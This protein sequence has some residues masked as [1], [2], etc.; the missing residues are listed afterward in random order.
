MKKRIFTSLGKIVGFFGF[1][2]TA[3]TK[4]SNLANIFLLVLREGSYYTIRS[5]ESFSNSSSF[6]EDC[7]SAQQINKKAE[8]LKV[9]LNK[10]SC[11]LVDEILRRQKYIFTHNLLDNR[12]IFSQEEISEQRTISILLKKKKDCLEMCSCPESFFYH[13][14]LKL[15]PREVIKNIEGKDVIDGGAYIGDSALTFSRD[16]FFRKIYSFEPERQLYIKLKK[17]IEKYGM[18]NTIAVKK[19]IGSKEKRAIMKF[20]DMSSRILEKGDQEIEVV[21]IDN[22][23]RE[24]NCNI[25]LIKF[26]IEGSELEGLLGA[27][28]TIKKFKPVLLISIYHSGKDFFEIKPYLEDLNLGYKFAVKKL[29]PS[30]YVS[31]VVLMAYP[32]D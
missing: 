29:N 3:R 18:R 2:Q 5:K 24:N 25:G 11:N 7:L 10:D 20:E 17:N 14:G 27:V 16:Y 19:G 31:E 13:H 22:F 8:N 15:L 12:I 23:V 28:D 1:C 30:S 26:D 32:Y 4:I 9:N 6:F 21:T